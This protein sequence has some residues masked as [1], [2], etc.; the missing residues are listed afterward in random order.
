MCVL[1]RE[2]G[3][4]PIFSYEALRQSTNCFHEENEIGVGGLGSVYLGKLSDG[5]TV[6][7]KRLSHDNSRRV[8]QFDQFINEVKIFSTLNHPHIVRLCGCTPAH[9]P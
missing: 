7:V 4:L 3:H 1:G 5:R 2:T 6:A 8:D 9:S